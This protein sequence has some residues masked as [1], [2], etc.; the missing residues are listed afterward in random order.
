MTPKKLYLCEM[1]YTAKLA[2]FLAALQ[3]NASSRGIRDLM[4]GIYG[5]IV[6]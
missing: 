1:K 4:W 6:S 2:T 3:L 5:G